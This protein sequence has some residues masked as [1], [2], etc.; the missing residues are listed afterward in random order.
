MTRKV[1]DMNLRHDL[2][3]IGPV[4]IDE[5]S[6]LE[7]SEKKRVS[8]TKYLIMLD[9]TNQQLDKFMSI[10]ELEKL[11]REITTINTELLKISILLSEKSD[12]SP[13][14]K[15]ELKAA[16]ERNTDFLMDLLVN[17]LGTSTG[18]IKT[19]ELRK[20]EKAFRKKR[21][22][23]IYRLNRIKK[24]RDNGIEL[25]ASEITQLSVERNE[26]LNK[27]SSILDDPDFFYGIIHKIEL[28]ALENRKE[29]AVKTIDK[30]SRLTGEIVLIRA[31]RIIISLLFDEKISVEDLKNIL[32]INSNPVFMQYLL[33]LRKKLENSFGSDNY[34][35]F[36]QLIC[37]VLSKPE[38]FNSGLLKKT[39]D[40]FTRDFFLNTPE[41]HVTLIKNARAPAFLANT[42]FNVSKGLLVKAVSQAK[43]NYHSTSLADVLT[44]IVRLETRESTVLRI[45][46]LVADD[47]IRKY[48]FYKVAAWRD[49]LSSEIRNFI[50]DRTILDLSDLPASG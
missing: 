32:N 7:S 36:K 1:A 33:I 40:F 10:G 34:D 23:L 26:L 39:Y 35:E 42:I 49:E 17:S 18:K 9:K 44:E 22:Q 48:R 38:T 14:E 25:S 47:P 24:Q 46:S 21:E 2:E 27:V 4:Y 3:R 43:I 30:L 11:Q 5:S 41:L 15:E 45:L 50:M 13:L 29:K 12:L 31:F 16:G 19:E 37:L 28:Y 20:K 6:A 8:L